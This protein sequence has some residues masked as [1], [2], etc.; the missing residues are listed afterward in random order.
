MWKVL[1]QFVC[2]VLKKITEIA[3]SQT[4][5]LL[6]C[7]VFLYIW[8]LF[9]RLKISEPLLLLQRK[10]VLYSKMISQYWSKCTFPFITHNVI[11]QPTCTKTKN[12]QIWYCDG[13]T[14]P[15]PLFFSAGCSTPLFSGSFLLFFNPPISVY[16]FAFRRVC[17]YVCGWRVRDEQR[18]EENA[19][20]AV[21]RLFIFL[22]LR[23]F[24]IGS[25]KN[26]ENFS[27]FLVVELFAELY[28]F[29]PKHKFEVCVLW[30]PKKPS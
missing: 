16:V 19:L 10:C 13:L 27:F 22:F 12:L 17:V 14:L 30:E 15:L 4:G 26:S 2:D 28:S 11:C 24:F 20:A 3:L 6:Y 8:S 29:F 7:K 21:S 23:F 18:K 5:P 9:L 25:K 1:A